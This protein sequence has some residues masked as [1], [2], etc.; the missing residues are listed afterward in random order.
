[1]VV[2]VH[3][4]DEKN[5]F[6][7]ETSVTKPV[8]EVVDD[9]VDLRACRSTWSISSRCEESEADDKVKST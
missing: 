2:L 1:M 6:M 7:Y 5:Q 8:D 4:V 3:K 9:I